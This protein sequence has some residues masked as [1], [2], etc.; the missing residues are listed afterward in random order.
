MNLEFNGNYFEQTK[1]VHP[2]SNN[3]VNIYIVYKLDPTSSSRNTDYTIQN[4]LFGAVK[5][6]KNTDISKYKYEGYGICFDE[7]GKFSH[8]VKKGNFNHTTLARNVLIFG[9]DMSFSTRATN[10]ANNIYFMGNFAL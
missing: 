3:A 8:T 4:T 10:K 7:G 9:V 1:V 6:T 5:I 2:N